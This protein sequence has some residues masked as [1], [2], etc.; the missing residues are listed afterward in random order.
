MAA[1]IFEIELPTG[2]I[3]EIEAPEDTPVEQVKQRAM[4]YRYERAG[5][6]PNQYR[7]TEGNNFFQNLGLGATQSLYSIPR[8]I[9]QMTGILSQE[10]IDERAKYD[11]DLLSTGGGFTGNILGNI[12][13][14][15][16]P[17][18]AL[19]KGAA[20][21]TNL[22]KLG[23]ALINPQ[24]ARTAMLT[25]G[26]QG[27][28]APVTTEDRTGVMG[29][30]MGGRAGNAAFAAGAGGLGYGAVRG[31]GYT[32]EKLAPY[33]PKLPGASQREAVRLA[34]ENASNPITAA[35]DMYQA[36]EIVPGSRPMAAEVTDDIKLNRFANMM[37][38]G[39]DTFAEMR[40]VRDV[41]NNEA[42]ADYVTQNF[43]QEAARTA[44]DYIQRLKGVAGVNQQ[45]L[46]DLES[47]DL[48]NPAIVDRLRSMVGDADRA[49]LGSV[50]GIDTAPVDAETISQ[51]SKHVNQ[52]GFGFTKVAKFIRDNVPTFARS[53][54]PE[55]RLS[56][57]RGLLSNFVNTTTL[58]NNDAYAIQQAIKALPKS[59]DPL[60]L[61]RALKPG[62]SKAKAAVNEAR[63][64]LAQDTRQIDDLTTL[65]NMRKDI[66]HALST[67]KLLTSEGLDARASKEAMTNIIKKLDE[68]IEAVSPQW[69][70]YMDNQSTLYRAEDQTNIGSAVLGLRKKGDFRE[71][72]AGK[73]GQREK[74]IASVTD[75]VNPMGKITPEQ[76]AALDNLEADIVR[77][78]RGKAHGAMQ[79]QES[80]ELP[81]IGMLNPTVEVARKTLKEIGR[82]HGEETMILMREALA[83]PQDYVA[84]L[85]QIPTSRL[86][87]IIR[88][89]GGAAALG[90]N[91]S[92][93]ADIRNENTRLR[94]IRNRSLSGYPM[95]DE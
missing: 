55:E 19:A 1:H 56:D 38:R 36:T 47:S 58:P 67:G 65:Y 12:A 30:M 85:A 16:A 17:G 76:N 78:Y 54:P 50:R 3:L 20:A 53:V 22:A 71:G 18:A 48:T 89:F 88:M 81:G 69:R 73:I 39:D 4:A 94:R 95:T 43:Q 77:R 15:V 79:R 31:L 74:F 8:G 10:D 26:V 11:A 49:S 6:D 63:A 7:P 72:A 41:M 64:L 29:Q 57:A 60:K 75:D 24:T 92:L 62:N 90:L 91:N 61:L 80:P 14:V 34:H 83:N 86:E 37:E 27:G 21:T 66:A 51:L 44:R 2:E 25:A 40:R 59:D 28:L 13:Q 52:H 23:T 33:L 93:M 5:I 84:L 87:D 9:G 32:A 35:S 70:K 82:R 46:K 42:R 68:Q 45:A